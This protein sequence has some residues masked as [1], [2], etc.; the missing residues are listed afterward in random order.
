MKKVIVTGA[1]GL[2]G[3]NL[4]PML[5]KSGYDVIAIDRNK[6]AS[7]S[8]SF[9]AARKRTIERAPTRPRDSAREDFTIAMISMVVIDI[10]IKLRAN[11]LRFERDS[12]Y[13]TYMRDK[14]YER[15]A[16]N[17]R[18]RTNPNMETWVL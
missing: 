14:I 13:S 4:V 6:Y 7:S 12:P 17:N 10:S 15:R 16:T 2:V 1:A 3:Q 8:G 11:I 9:M 5:V 18:L